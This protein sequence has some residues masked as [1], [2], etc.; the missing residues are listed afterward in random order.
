MSMKFDNFWFEMPCYLVG[1]VSENH[2]AC[3]LERGRHSDPLQNPE[4]GYPH[5]NFDGSYLTVNVSRLEY[6]NTAST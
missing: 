2:T 4:D 3:I 5:L 1:D 6:K